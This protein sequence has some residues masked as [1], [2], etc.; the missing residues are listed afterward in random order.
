MAALAALKRWLAA[1]DAESREREKVS[2][3]EIKRGTPHLWPLMHRKNQALKVL[4]E[5]ARALERA[6]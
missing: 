4:E 3:G 1:V 2:S 5:A 6:S